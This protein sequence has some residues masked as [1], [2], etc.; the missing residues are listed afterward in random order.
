MAARLEIV[1]LNMRRREPELDAKNRELSA[2]AAH[3]AQTS[4]IIET[5]RDALAKIPMP[6]PMLVELLEEMS[7]SIS[8]EDE[9]ESF[10]MH[11]E[12]AH[13][14]FFAALLERAPQLWPTELRLCA[15]P[16]MNLSSKQIG[17]ML[18]VRESSV[19]N[20]RSRIRSKLD[21]PGGQALLDYLFSL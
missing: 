18:N 13:P 4:S 5:F 11:F 10:K 16:R 21:L 1:D 2:K 17:A 12:A 15:Y 3:L 14:R 6:D 9:W 19:N 7:G 20:N 8:S